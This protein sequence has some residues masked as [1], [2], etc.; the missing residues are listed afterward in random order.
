[1]HKFIAALVGVI[2]LT[3]ATIGVASAASGGKA[4]LQQCRSQL[5]RA[6]TFN[7]YPR[8]YCRNKCQYFGSGR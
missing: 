3:A 6:G 5:Q 8:G 4:C 2:A 1:M 7:S